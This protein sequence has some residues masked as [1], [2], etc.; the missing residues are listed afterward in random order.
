MADT[1]GG[2]AKWDLGAPVA[3]V[4]EEERG[5]AHR[6]IEAFRRR[7]WV[8]ALTTAQRWVSSSRWQSDWA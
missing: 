2:R 8:F 6:V 1:G 4:P 7:L 3:F 5:G